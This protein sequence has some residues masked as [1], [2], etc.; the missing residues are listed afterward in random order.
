MTIPQ[1]LTEVRSYE[2]HLEVAPAPGSN[3]PRISW[4][5][6]YFYF[7]PD[8]EIPATR[9]PYA[10]IITKDYPDD[11]A[12]H[13]DPADRWRLNIHVGAQVLAELLG[14][15]PSEITSSHEN[16]STFDAFHPHPLYAAG[17]WVCVVNP[18]AETLERALTA[19]RDAHLAECNR[20]E[21]SQR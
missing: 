5:D 13:L 9:Q 3:Y 14:G 2:G 4:G 12:S 11:T 7:A 6:F 15:T 16:Y 19:L 10:T 1:I 8:G 18:G 21:R 17:G 20:V